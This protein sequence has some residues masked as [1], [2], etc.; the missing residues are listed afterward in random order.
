[1]NIAEI[2]LSALSR[3]CLAKRRIDRLTIPVLGS[4]RVPVF[5]IY[6]E[7]PVPILGNSLKAFDNKRVRRQEAQRVPFVVEQLGNAHAFLVVLSCVILRRLFEQFPVPGL[8]AFHARQG[9]KV[10]FSCIAD[11]VFDIPFLVAR[12][13]IAE[14]D[15]KAVVA[16]EPKKYLAQGYSVAHTPAYPCRV[17]E[18]D[19]AGNAPDMVEDI[20]QSLCHACGGFPV[21]TLCKAR[22]AERKGQREVCNLPSDTGF[23][24]FG[25]SEIGLRFTFRPYQ[26][27]IALRFLL[28]RFSL[29]DI[30][31]D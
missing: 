7:L 23:Y 16:F 19:P 20:F 2:E 25:F 26:L 21:E 15:R 9:H 31:L 27:K 12:R 30:A 18:H 24:E 11:F 28:G 10:V 29:F 13:G 3:H 14:T 8:E 1:M 4:T 17:V 6:T 5:A 22:I